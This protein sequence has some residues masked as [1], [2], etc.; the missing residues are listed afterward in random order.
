MGDIS[1]PEGRDYYRVTYRHVN[2]GTQVRNNLAL[3]EA[4]EE[5][6][7]I[8]REAEV[9]KLVSVEHVVVSVEVTDVM[10]EIEAVENEKSAATEVLSHYCN[11][12][13]HPH[14]YHTW[15]GCAMPLD[16]KGGIWMGGPYDVAAGPCGC[17]SS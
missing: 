15:A 17:T 3:D 1:I 14:G 6:K 16:V 2:M 9:R 12:C 5:V 4:V 11:D 8:N 10:A 7:K 13:H